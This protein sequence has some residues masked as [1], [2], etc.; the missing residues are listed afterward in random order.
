MLLLFAAATLLLLFACCCA[1]VVA[2]ALAA[3]AAAAE[4]LCTARGPPNRGAPKGAPTQEV[5]LGPLAAAIEGQ[6]DLLQQRMQQQLEQQQQQQREKQQQQQQ[7]RMRQQRPQQHNEERE[8]RR[9]TFRG[10]LTASQQQE[11]EALRAA[12]RSVQDLWG[13]PGALRGDRG[14]P[15]EALCMP[16]L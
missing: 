4:A 15:R 14:G 9:P 1:A 7:Q 13:P 6:L 16:H 5:L 11:L 3:A 12:L 10:P 2:A 8:R